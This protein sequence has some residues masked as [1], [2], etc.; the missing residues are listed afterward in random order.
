M[1]IICAS[2]NKN[3]LTLMQAWRHYGEMKSDL[4]DHE[5]EVFRLLSLEL[6]RLKELSVSDQITEVLKSKKGSV[7]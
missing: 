7:R 3:E 1:C 6:E 5:E 4:G 2:W